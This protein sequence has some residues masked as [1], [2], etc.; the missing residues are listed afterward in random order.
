VNDELAT[1]AKFTIK[2]GKSKKKSDEES[3]DSEKSKDESSED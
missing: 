2:A 3:E 1:T